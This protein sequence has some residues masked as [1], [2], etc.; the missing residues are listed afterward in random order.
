MKLSVIIPTLNGRELLEH[1]LPYLFV[2]LK[3]VK[4]NEVIIVDNNSSD[5]T[6][7]LVENYKVIKF[8]KLKRNYGFAGAVDKGVLSAKGEYVLILNNDCFVM[9]DTIAKMLQFMEKNPVYVATQ[10]VV[11]KLESY[12][13]IKS[14]KFIKWKK[15]KIEHIGYVV[16]LYKGKAEIIQDARWWMTDV[17]LKERKRYVR[18]LSGTCLLV[19]RDVF[20]KLSM[21]DA[22]FHSY[23]E[24]VDFFIRCAKAGYRYFPTLS[25]SA[26][27][28]HRTTSGRMGLYKERRDLVNWVRIIIKN[29][30]FSF[31]IRR[32]S[33]LLVERLRNMSGLVK[34]FIKLKT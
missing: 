18:G 24:D 14:A 5:K 8:V 10:P 21:F 34:K 2:A 3:R 11:Y 16:D 4:N 31:L 12:K 9:P 15:E 32:F 20:E 22:S 19:K 27:H 26:F 28:L 29:Y 25:A 30:P 13:V 23:L 33:S 1:S 7:E 6:K 17:G